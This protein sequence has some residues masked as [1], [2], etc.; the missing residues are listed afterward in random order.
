MAILAQIF[1][2]TASD[3]I[4]VISPSR[5]EGEFEEVRVVELVL[6]DRFGVFFD[7][8]IHARH[9]VTL[10]LS[11]RT[12]AHGALT[13]W[14]SRKNLVHVE[15]EASRGRLLSVYSYKHRTRGRVCD[16]FCCACT[17]TMN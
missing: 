3:L 12:A 4:L 16:R 15:S 11:A 2:E 13:P 17:R 9:R 6:K 7:F 14:A 1:R 8:R 10:G 5:Y